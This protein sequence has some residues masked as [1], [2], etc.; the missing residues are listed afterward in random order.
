VVGFSQL[1]ALSDRRLTSTS[2]RKKGFNYQRSP[3]ALGCKSNVHELFLTHV[4]S[5]PPLLLRERERE[6]QRETE[7]DRERQR[8]TERDRERQ[9]E[10]ERQ[11][12]RETERQGEA[13]RDSETGRKTKRDTENYTKRQTDRQ[14]DKQTER[15]YFSRESLFNRG[16]HSSISNLELE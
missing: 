7:R 5:H 13:E 8:E 10:T 12:Y 2:P 1:E 6:R 3:S 9:R 4:G 11:R 15:F 14:T 16:I